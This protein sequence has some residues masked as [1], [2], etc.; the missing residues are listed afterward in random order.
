MNRKEFN[1]Y[2]IFIAIIYIA[3]AAMILVAIVV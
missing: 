3:L 1:Y 2:K